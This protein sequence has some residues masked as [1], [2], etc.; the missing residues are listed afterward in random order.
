MGSRP[1]FV[2][3]LV[4]GFGGGNI[5]GSVVGGRYSDIV[6]ARLKA[7]NGGKSVP[8]F[9]LRATLAPMPLIPLAFVA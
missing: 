3:C 9:R 1:D 6:L 4:T 5:I 8:E 7:N 2:F